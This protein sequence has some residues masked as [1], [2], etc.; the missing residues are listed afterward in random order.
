M[1]VLGKMLFMNTDIGLSDGFHMS[2]NIKVKAILSSR[3]KQNY[4]P[5]VGKN[6][7]NYEKCP[8][9]EASTCQT[10]SVLSLEVCKQRK[11]DSTRKQLGKVQTIVC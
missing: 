3:A 1:A 5:V 8:Y 10:V 11:E 7:H 4:G 6:L 9:M 2:Q